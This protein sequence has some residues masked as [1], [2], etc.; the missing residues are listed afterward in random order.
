MVLMLVAMMLYA[1]HVR[2]FSKM[3]NEDKTHLTHLPFPTESAFGISDRIL[4]RCCMLMAMTV[5]MA[6]VVML[7]HV[8]VPP[9][10]R[11]SSIESNN[12]VQKC[13]TENV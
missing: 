4:R 3:T 8:S 12:T 10:S 9:P 7:C 11:R 1:T 5:I 2:S 6:M 13:D